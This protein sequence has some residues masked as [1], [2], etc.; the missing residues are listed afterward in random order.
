[1]NRRRSILLILAVITLGGWLWWRISDRVIAELRGATGEPIIRVREIQLNAASLGGVLR[2]NE[3]VYRCEYYR[4]ARWPMFSCESY[5]GESYEVRHAEVKW[6]DPLTA[7]VTL[8]GQ[9]AFECVDGK[10]RKSKP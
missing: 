3:K 9:I 1:M 8:D 2:V 4:Y 10:W 7:R 6:I 5:A